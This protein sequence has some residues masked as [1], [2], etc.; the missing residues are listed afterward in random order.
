MLIYLLAIFLQSSHVM[1]NHPDCGKQEPERVGSSGVGHSTGEATSILKHP[2]A[3][4]ILLSDKL[5]CSGSI[6]N[7]RYVLSAA[8]CFWVEGI[9]LDLTKL[10]IIAGSD[11][12]VSPILRSKARFVERKKVVDVKKHPL[13]DYPAA[14]Y[15]LA[16]VK[17]EGQFTFRDSRW[18]ICLPEATRSRAY[19]FGRGYTLVGFGRD[20]NKE[21]QGSV[22]TDLDLIVQPT[23]ACMAKYSG[24]L[25]DELNDFHY[26]IKET[27]PQN[28]N[29][30]SLIC[31]AK[32]GKTSGSCPGDSGGIFMNNMWKPDLGDYRAIQTAVVHG[33]PQR[34]NGGRYPSI[35]VR[36]DNDQ[37]LTWIKDIAFSN[38]T[39][40]R[41]ISEAFPTY[42]PYI[43]CEGCQCGT[44]TVCKNR[45]CQCQSG[46]SGD[47]FVSCN[48]NTKVK[49]GVT[50][51]PINEANT[52]K[53][54]GGCYMFVDQRKTF[55]E[56]KTFCESK[57]G[58]LFE[59]RT[60]QT[61]KLVYDKGVEVLTTDYMWIGIISKTGKSGPWK[62]ATS[63][64]D[65]IQTIWRSDQPNDSGSELCGYYGTSEREKWLDYQCTHS[66]RFICE[67]V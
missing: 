12:P 59:P 38:V 26:L 4:A 29:E 46:F 61:N 5:H 6:L 1:S 13:A 7:E 51:C 37:A 33:A 28:F 64:E 67:F 14:R 15:D 30:D 39:K 57:R 18:P 54:D 58:R 44:N 8:H 25:N 24:I 35:F 10:A 42:T 40:C 47:P 45:V 50:N 17:I 3:I 22:L 41:E 27:L 34:C 43:N 23:N 48:G 19:H 62:F 53:I 52:F 11:D 56:A 55:N 63:G 65:I 66:Y 32:P 49:T 21:N 20:I 60:V 31:G 36:I 16:L 9:P 2:W